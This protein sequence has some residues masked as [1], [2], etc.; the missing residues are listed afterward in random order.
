MKLK[1]IL[2]TVLDPALG[3]KIRAVLVLVV[4]F[5]N[6]LIHAIDLSKAN[7]VTLGSITFAGAL[8]LVTHFSK[9]GNAK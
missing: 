6:W 8:Q 4:A 9:I 1:R 2:N 7:G 5:A 3:G